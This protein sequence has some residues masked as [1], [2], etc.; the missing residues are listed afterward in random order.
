MSDTLDVITHAPAIPLENVEEHRKATPSRLWQQLGLG[1]V[2]LI[3]I[4]MNFFQLGQNGFA[5]LAGV[6]APWLTGWVVQQTGQFYW[7]FVVAAA[8]V[9]AAAAL[10]VMGVGRIEQVD[11]S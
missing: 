5:N 8:I 10:F 4:F 6:V 11:F 9:V 1:G 2:M 3:S 7:A